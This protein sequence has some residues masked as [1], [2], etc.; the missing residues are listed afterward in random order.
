MGTRPEARAS[1]VTG[2]PSRAWAAAT[3][4]AAFHHEIPYLIDTQWVALDAPSPSHAS[5]RSIRAMAARSALRLPD[6]CMGGVGRAHG[7]SFRLEH[8]FETTG[9]ARSCL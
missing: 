3:H 5:S 7:V 6:G 4:R 9:A 2:R 8:V 1:A